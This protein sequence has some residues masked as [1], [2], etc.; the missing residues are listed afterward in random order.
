MFGRIS[1]SPAKSKFS[2]VN[3]SLE[4]DELVP[5]DQKFG[6]GSSSKKNDDLEDDDDK[7]PL[8]FVDVNLGEDQAVRIVVH[9]GDTAEG[10]AK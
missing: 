9:E 10:L 7:T 2:L 5:A 1:I 4:P 6:N 3:F 8:L